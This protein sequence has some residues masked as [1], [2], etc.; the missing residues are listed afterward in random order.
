M[1]RIATGLLHD[2]FSIVDLFFVGRL[3]PP[4]ISAV[5]ISGTAVSILLMLGLGITVG[6]T[7]LV[8]QAIGAGNGDRASMVTIQGLLMAAVLSLVTAAA[9]PFASSCLKI[10]GAGPGVAKVGT[11]YLQVSLIGSCTM[12]M[13]ITFAAVLTVI[14]GSIGRITPRRGGAPRDSREE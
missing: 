9:F 2:S 7:A 6:C 13:S 12:Y 10:L 3:G 4:A 1:P 14:F 8:S 11:S 5:T